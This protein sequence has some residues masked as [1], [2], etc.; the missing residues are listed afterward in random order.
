M[1]IFTISECPDQA[2]R[3]LVDKHCVKQILESCQLLCTT[4][5]EQ[6]IEA[7][8]RPTHAN[9]P[10]RLWVKSSYDNFQWLIAHAHA[11]ANEYT[12][13]YKKI[14]K[15]QAVLEWC[16]DHAHLLG[17][18]SYDLTPFAIA[19]A[20]DCECRKLPNFESLSTIEKY[21]F[22]YKLDKK[23]LHQ[24]KRNKPTWL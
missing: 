11:I 20:D 7:P 9:H 24:W 22:Y 8:Y 4:Y 15:S 16:E 17:F 5:H 23:H 3:W 1:N 2:A 18:D 19:I 6:N 21:R 10:S 13:R 14:H 12:E